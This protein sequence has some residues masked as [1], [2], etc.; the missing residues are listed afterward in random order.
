MLL[1]LT[2][3]LLKDSLMNSLHLNKNIRLNI[4]LPKLLLTQLLDS[5]WKV[6]T[7]VVFAK[8]SMVKY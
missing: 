5:R 3:A 6:K 2:F 4:Q 7:N 8:N 1:L